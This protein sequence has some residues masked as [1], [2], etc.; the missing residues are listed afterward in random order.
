MTVLAKQARVDENG[1]EFWEAEVRFVLKIPLLLSLCHSKYCWEY[2]RLK[3]V[4]CL[5]RN[6]NEDYYTFICIFPEMTCHHFG[7]FDFLFSDVLLM[8]DAIAVPYLLT[9]SRKAG[10]D[11]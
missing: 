1:E 8:L 11:S 6:S 7:R 4:G 9:D 5:F 3:F 10:S 2:A